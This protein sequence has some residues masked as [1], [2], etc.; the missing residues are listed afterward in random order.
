MGAQTDI[1]RGSGEGL[2]CV[3]RYFS[4]WVWCRYGCRGGWGEC[5]ARGGGVGLGTWAR[6]ETGRLSPGQ[7]LWFE[8]TGTLQRMGS[9][10]EMVFVCVLCVWWWWG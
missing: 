3:K 2:L 8:H 10:A 4:A 9:G 7:A 6:I 5:G 1:L